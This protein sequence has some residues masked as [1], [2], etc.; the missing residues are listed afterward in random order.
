MSDHN[1]DNQN[2][3][4]RPGRPRKSSAP[5][6]N[7]D[8]LDQALVHGVPGPDGQLQYPSFR[9][10]A[11]RFGISTGTVAQ[12]AR[13][14]NCLERRRTASSQVQELADRKLVEHRAEQLAFEKEDLLRIM[15]QYFAAFEKALR[16]GRVRCDNPSDYNQMCRLRSFMMGDAD[17][18]RE[19]FSGISLDELQARHKRAK[20]LAAEM[21]E[22]PAMTGMIKH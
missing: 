6:F 19:V 8:E 14:H 18:R 20:E 1:N 12:Y 4:R 5:A 3:V 7:A 10:V 9:D 22:L 2:R 16:D 21:E 13:S 15:D 17:S 11:E